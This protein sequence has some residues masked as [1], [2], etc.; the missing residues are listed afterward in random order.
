MHL[1]S[2]WCVTRKC[3]GVT[4]ACESGP[5][6]RLRN[7]RNQPVP[8]WYIAV[9]NCGQRIKDSHRRKREEPKVSK[10]LIPTLP[11]TE[12]PF[13]NHNGTNVWM[14]DSPRLPCTSGHLDAAAVQT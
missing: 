3:A 13:W 11:L 7:E 4:N 6:C 12:F 14:C 2:V 8:A 10:S 5:N 9:S 1:S